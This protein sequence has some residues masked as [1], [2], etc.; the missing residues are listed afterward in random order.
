MLGA[1]R[2]IRIADQGYISLPADLMHKHRLHAGD[3]VAVEDTDQGVLITREVGEEPMTT[4]HDARFTY[5]PP[6]P[7]E[8]A[9][10]VAAVDRILA[11][12]ATM[13]SIAPLTTA[14]LVHLSRD[15]NFWYGEEEPK[16][17]GADG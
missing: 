10:R 9:R 8:L 6:T 2:R 14:D 3:E 11:T 4:D 7:A 17:N 13:P 5:T 12:R 1:R 16:K 15:D